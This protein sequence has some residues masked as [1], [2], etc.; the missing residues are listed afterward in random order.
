MITKTREIKDAKKAFR[1]SKEVGN[2]KPRLM[3]TDGLQSYNTAF[4][5]GFYDRHQSWSA[6]CGLKCSKVI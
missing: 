4:N 1:K 6:E 2:K 5:S 3:V